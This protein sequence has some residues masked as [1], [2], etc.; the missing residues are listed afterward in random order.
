MINVI[1]RTNT[2]LTMSSLHIFYIL[3]IKFSK[4]LIILITD[5]NK[6]IDHQALTVGSAVLSDKTFLSSE[7]VTDGEL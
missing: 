2:V 3:I 1:P 6:T 7:T 5:L 4:T